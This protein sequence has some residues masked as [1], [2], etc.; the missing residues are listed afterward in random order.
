MLG[1]ICW[2]AWRSAPTANASSPAALAAP[3]GSGGVQLGRWSD[4]DSCPARLQRQAGHQVIDVPEHLSERTKLATILV[5]FWARARRGCCR[6]DVGEAIRPRTRPACG[7]R[8]GWPRCRNRARNR[9]WSRGTASAAS[10]A[11]SGSTFIHPR[12]PLGAAHSILCGRPHPRETTPRRVAHDLRSAHRLRDSDGVS[13]PS[14]GHGGPSRRRKGCSSP[15]T[16]IRTEASSVGSTSSDSAGSAP[17]LRL[18][19]FVTLLWIACRA[20]SRS[21]HSSTRC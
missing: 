9:G 3:C 18:V 2:S 13:I 6:A 16:K 12:E 1:S 17:V 15:V 21:C 10:P 7:S 8:R 19:R 20:W 11:P 4:C 5:A 14:P